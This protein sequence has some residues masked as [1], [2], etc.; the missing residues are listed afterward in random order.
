MKKV[1]RSA[2]GRSIDM[3][4]IRL[5]NEEVIAVGNM[6]VNARG[7]ELGP[8]GEIVRTRNEIMADYYKLSTPTVSAA[9]KPTVD[10]LSVHQRAGDTSTQPAMRGTLASTVA[11][12]PKMLDDPNG[13][14]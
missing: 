6:R 3:D 2:L 11:R 4:Q 10:E 13:E 7:D 9:E 8:G 1:Y 5:V 14:K 12:N